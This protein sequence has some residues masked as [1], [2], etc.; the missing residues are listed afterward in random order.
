MLEAPK[1]VRTFGDLGEFVLGTWGRWL[2]TI[3]HM[4]TCILVPIAFLVLGGTL[5]TTLFPA[6]FEPETW[7]IIMGITLLPLGLIPTLKEGA[8]MAAAGFLS[9]II[10]NV[11]ALGMLVD[12]MHSTNV[13]NLSVPSPNL[14]FKQ[15]ATVFGNLAL[16]YGAGLTLPS[17]QREHSEPQRMPRVIIVSLVLI[18]LL[19]FV[20]SVIAVA[21]LGC[22]IPGNLIY[23]IAGNDLGSA[24][25]RG[26]V[27][28]TY[29]AMQAHI[30]I[31]FTVVVLPAFYVLERLFLG[32]HKPIGDATQAPNA[33][34]TAHSIDFLSL[35]SLNSQTTVATDDDAHD[36]DSATY[37]QPGVFPKVAVLRIVTVA[38]CVVVAVLWKDR[39]LDLLD[40]VGGSTYSLCCMIVPMVLSL[41]HFGKRLHV[42]ERALAILAC[43]IVAFLGAYV[44]YITAGPLF[45]PAPK[46]IDV[47]IWDSPKFSYC[48]ESFVN[49]IY[50]NTSYH[51]AWRKP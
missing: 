2:V 48:S 31:A 20:D 18:T 46:A 6:S 24:F 16:T 29:L 12:K 25:N 33:G 49:V 21:Y 14:S 17:L 13:D 38:C 30:T 10:A 40:F 22:Q 50:T 23:A 34:D 3:P 27:V 35:N 51:S 19:F 42:V 9:T 39:L 32:L 43:L 47:T 45:S 15:V 5:L 1:H 8:M 37:S 7:I 28:I 41:K 44:T 26:G 4:I 11:V 36:I